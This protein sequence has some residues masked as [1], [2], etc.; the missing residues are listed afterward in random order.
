MDASRFAFADAT[1]EHFAA[2]VRIERAAGGSS[3]VA[4]TE[5]QA[6]EEALRRRHFVSVALDRGTVAGWIWFSIDNS[7]G[8]EEVGQLFRVAVGAAWSRTG[9]GRALVE[10]A[11]TTLA[12]RA[13]TRMRA[14]LTGDDEAT[15]AFLASIGYVVDAVIMERPL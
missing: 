8:G 1:P 12:A 9:V 11:Q 2:I 4:L 3:L 13:C 6:L 10:H 5:G 7:R 14:T 15:R